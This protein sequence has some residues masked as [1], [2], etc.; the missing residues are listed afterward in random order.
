MTTQIICWARTPSDSR[1]TAGGTLSFTMGDTHIPAARA[2]K[3]IDAG[4]STAVADYVANGVLIPSPHNRPGF[5]PARGHGVTVVYGN[6]R[7]K[8]VREYD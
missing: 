5:R 6:G 7:R 8:T 4:G 3:R 2:A 1:D